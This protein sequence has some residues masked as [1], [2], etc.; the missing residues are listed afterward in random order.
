MNIY[1]QLKKLFSVL[2]EHTVHKKKFVLMLLFS[3]ISKL[4][5]FI[6]PW[7]LGQLFNR[8]QAI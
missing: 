3:F 8:I 4:L 6:E 1:Q 7:I 5:W 2:W